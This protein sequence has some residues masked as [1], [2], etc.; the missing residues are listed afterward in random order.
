MPWPLSTVG[1]I[2][3]A[4]PRRIAL[5]D[6]EF[7]QY[8]GVKAVNWSTLKHMRLSPLHYLHATRTVFEDTPRLGV[9]RAVHTATLEPDEFPLSY[10]VF[11]GKT[12][13]GKEWD[14]FKAAN[15]D[16]TILK[17]SEYATAL[18]IRDAIRSHPTARKFL[19]AGGYIE[20]SITWID[21]ATGLKCKG[22]PDI[23][24]AAVV[25]IKTCQSVDERRFASL[26]A[27][28]GYFNQLAFYRAGVFAIREQIKPCVI[29]AAEL[30]PPHDVGVFVVDDDSLALAEE[31]N[32]RLLK[33][34]A[35]CE[36]ANEW[37][38]RY[39]ESRELTLPAWMWSEEEQELTA[40]VIEDGNEE[41]IAE[42]LMEE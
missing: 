38:G 41:S 17:R 30:A 8:R 23:E 2:P 32:A 40:R 39:P 15:S 25:D 1:S 3:T 27:R 24:G 13:K 35:E 33:R 34:V 9:G 10:V 31:E 12:R 18:K 42:A 36:A 21:P 28:M 14:A 5:T 37:P 16:K 7:E 6:I 29:I 26:A 19:D 11:G 4:R 22:R 20:R